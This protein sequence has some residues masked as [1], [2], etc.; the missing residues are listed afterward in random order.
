MFKKMDKKK[1]VIIGSGFAVL[2]LIILGIVM[3]GS[4]TGKWKSNIFGDVQYSCSE[5]KVSSSGWKSGA[6]SSGSSTVDPPSSCTT[7][8]YYSK[9][10]VYTDVPTCTTN[11]G[12][13]Q[14]PCYYEEVYTRTR[15]ATQCD[16]G[17]YLTNGTCYECE[18]GYYCED[19][20]TK[21]TCPVG[22]TSETGATSKDD[23][24]PT[25]TLSL[26]TYATTLDIGETYVIKPI[27]DGIDLGANDYNISCVS[28][29]EN[30]AT[31]NGQ[32]ITTIAES[33]IIETPAELI[34]FSIKFIQ[35]I[36]NS[37]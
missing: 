23:C 20:K 16:T 36:S 15:T 6:P 10:T 17:Y 11:T 8:T 22:S 28:N 30:V 24:T 31:V 34:M 9:V 2:L 18:A 37:L 19:G 3:T 32:K 21:T 5:W 29:N 7:Q 13:A 1:L 27:V 25:W 14:V 4:I 35:T 12:S 26:D 33:K